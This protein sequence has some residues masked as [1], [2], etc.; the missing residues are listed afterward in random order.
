M[1]TV[2]TKGFDKWNDV[3]KRTHDESRELFFRAGEVRWCIFGVNIGSEMDGK[4]AS[5]TRPALILHAIGSK[6]AL[7]LSLSTKVRAVPCYHVFEFQ[8]QTYSLCI[9]QLRIISSKRI[10]RRKGKITKNRLQSIKALVNSF[11][12]LG[13]HQPGSS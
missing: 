1:K 4:G 11:F 13:P 10:L 5:F 7:I 12:S 3:K 8:N 6:L 9:H 2:Y